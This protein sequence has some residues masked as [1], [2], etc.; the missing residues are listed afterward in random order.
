MKTYYILIL[1]IILVSCAEK[2]QETPTEIIEVVTTQKI[3]KEEFQFL[4]DSANLDG[5][6]L[7]YDTEEDTYYSN[8][9][10]WCEEGKIPASTFKIPNSIIALELGIA[11]NDSTIIKWDGQT[12]WNN[13]WNQDLIL[14]DAF[15]YSCVPCYQDIARQVGVKRMNEYVTKLA[16]GKMQVDSNNLDMFWLEGVS[17]INQFEQIDFL[18]RFY[19]NELPISSHSYSTMK[20]MMVIKDTNNYKISGK[21]GWGFQN[22]KDNVWFVGYLEI[23]NK[24]VYFATNLEPKGEFDINVLVNTRKE[25]TNKAIDLI[26]N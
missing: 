18:K 26:V 10:K 16:Y 15:H 14:R 13:N 8:D 19:Q 1:S 4:I 12:R 24:V 3:V 5:A 21:T 25:L 9:Y 2:K 20:K 7:I 11:K 23:N 22:G 6:I 17:E